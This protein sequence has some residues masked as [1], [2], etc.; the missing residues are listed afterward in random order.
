[1]RKLLIVI[2]VILVLSV[3]AWGA[4][5]APPPD[6]PPGLVRAL[7]AQVAHNPRLL[8][9]P[10][11]VGTAVGLGR[12]GAA[13]IRVFTARPGVGRVPTSLDGVPVVVQVTG[14]LVALKR[15]RNSPPVVTISAPPDG[16]AYAAG[17]LVSLS[18]TA[19][20][21]Q[22][23]DVSSRLTWASTLDGDLGDGSSIS[24]TLSAGTH[25]VTASATDSGGLTGTASVTI[26]VAASPGHYQTTDV[27]PRPVPVGVSAGNVTSVSAG[28]IACRVVDP[29]GTVYALSNT[30]V[31][32]PDD[33]AGQGALGAVVAQPGLYDAP[34]HVY[35]PATMYLGTVSAYKP[36]DG[37]ILAFNRIDAAIA[38]TDAAL[39]GTSTPLTLGGYGVPSRVTRPA[40]L[41]M[42][43]QKFGRTTMLTK[44]TV[45]GVNATMVV[46]YA[47]DWYAWFTGQIIVETPGVF[48]QAGDSGSLV[49]TDD[50]NA[51]PVGLLFAGN[52]E[53]TMAIVNPIDEV[54]EYFHVAIDGR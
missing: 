39:L 12:D 25:T 2:V 23:H 4:Q 24:R 27:W 13:V 47:D 52:A 46:G 19:W 21:K 15:V 32:A 5:A 48:E 18:A 17:A 16:A 31:F 14:D 20:D 34:S 33:V 1:M 6:G 37:S 40:T 45:T 9:T 41:N 28:T 22:E 42:A 53:G 43:V 38:L 3:P 10:G 51:D 54:L 11:V 7:A 8:A 44:G 29:E 26:T 49:V 36:I 35:D 30:H 50:A